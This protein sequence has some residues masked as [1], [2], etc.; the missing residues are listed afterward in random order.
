MLIESIMGQDPSSIDVVL[1]FIPQFLCYHADQWTNQP[2]NKSFIQ[3]TNQPIINSTTNQPT[4]QPT[5]KSFIQW[6]N[7]PIINS[8]NQPTNQPA[9]LFPSLSL[10]F[11]GN[12]LLSSV[13]PLNLDVTMARGSLVNSRLMRPDLVMDSNWK[14]PL[15]Q[16]L[17]TCKSNE[18]SPGERFI[19]VPLRWNMEVFALAM[20]AKKK[21]PQRSERKRRTHG[22]SIPAPFLSNPLSVASCCPTINTSFVFQLRQYAF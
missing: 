13:A 2:T 15:Q 22:Q 10:H 5:N 8:T 9:N 16:F 18:V 21:N 19:L 1:K 20:L 17:Y 3:W 12:T 4:N 11:W 14:C 7:Q 6:T